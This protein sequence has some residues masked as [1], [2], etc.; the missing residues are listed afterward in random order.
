[1]QNPM[2]LELAETM[3]DNCVGIRIERLHRIVSR[4]FEQQL[5]TVG[6]T[7]A[8][9]EVLAVLTLMQEARQS[10]LAQALSVDRSTVKRNIDVLERAELVER[11]TLPSGRTLGVSP[12]AKGLE[13]FAS[14]RQIWTEAQ[15]EVAEALGGNAGPILDDW[16]QSLAALDRP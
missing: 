3:R 2:A 10:T 7:L 4:H 14:A 1:M 6:L 11:K 15:G 13:A 9:L 8:Q 12:T 5:R 16:M